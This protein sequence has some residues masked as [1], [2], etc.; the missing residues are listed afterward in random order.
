MYFTKVLK[1]GLKY[2]TMPIHWSDMD[3]AD[4][5]YIIEII[6]NIVDITRRNG[7]YCRFRYPKHA[8]STNTNTEISNHV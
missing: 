2:R 1:Q 6:P 4:M 5:P 7:W 8:N 3:S